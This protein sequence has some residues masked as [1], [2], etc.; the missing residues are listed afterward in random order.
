MIYRR[1]MLERGPSTVKTIYISD[2]IHVINFF[3][4]ICNVYSIGDK[5]KY[6]PVN[7]STE[8]SAISNR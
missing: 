7:V 3:N 6:T 5:K 2:E 4:E 8:P 1:K